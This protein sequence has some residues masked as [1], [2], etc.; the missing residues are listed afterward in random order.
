MG[1]STIRSSSYTKI[2]TF[3]EHI[4]KRENKFKFLSRIVSNKASFEGRAQTGN[5]AICVRGKNIRKNLPKKTT[6]TKNFFSRHGILFRLA[7][8]KF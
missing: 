2:Y 1:L 5:L 3:K 6:G 8:E 7:V 4:E